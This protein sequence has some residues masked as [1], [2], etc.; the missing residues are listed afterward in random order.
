ML[1]I[2][3]VEGRRQR[4]LVVEGKVIAPW[5]AELKTACDHAKSDLNGREFLIE[6]RN[7]TTISQEGENVL[8]QLLEDGVK[9]R[10]S[11]VFAKQVLRQLSRRVG[12]NLQETKR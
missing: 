3:K 10:C 8:L 4:R 9:I 6:V 7:L 1:K 11:G 2:S 5:A 12:R